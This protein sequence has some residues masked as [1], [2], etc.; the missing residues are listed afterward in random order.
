M[1]KSSVVPEAA[2]GSPGVKNRVHFRNGGAIGGAAVIVKI[3]P[4][5]ADNLAARNC[6]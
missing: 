4:T 1:A 5:R 6:F 3:K 2:Y